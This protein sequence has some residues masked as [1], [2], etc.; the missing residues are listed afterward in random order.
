MRKTILQNKL[1]SSRMPFLWSA[2]WK[3]RATDNDASAQN[4]R[5]CSIKLDEHLLQL[6]GPAW[7]RIPLEIYEVAYLLG[8]KDLILSEIGGVTFTSLDISLFMVIVE[9][10]ALT[11]TKCPYLELILLNSNGGEVVNEIEMLNFSN[12]R[13]LMK[14]PLAE[15]EKKTSIKKLLCTD[16]PNLWSPPH[17]VASQGEAATMDFV[18]EVF[19]D[20]GLNI[21]M[22]LF[23]LGD[24]EAGKTSVL[25]SLK[26][27][28]NAAECIREDLRTVGIDLQ[29]WHV[30]PT[31][32]GPPVHFRVC[33]LAGQEVYEATHQFLL[34]LRAVYILVWRAVPHTDCRHNVLLD[35]VRHWLDLLQMR[36]P[37][38]RLLLVVTHIDT[39]DAK[40]LSTLCSGVKDTV[41]QRLAQ[42][43]EIA[44]Q[45]RLLTVLND[46]ESLRVNCL[47]GEGVAALRE[48]L[49][50]FTQSMPW[51]QE[52]LPKSFIS[53][54]DSVYNMVNQKEGTRFISAHEWVDLAR[55]HGMDGSMLQ[56]EQSSC[57]IL[58]CCAFSVTLQLLASSHH[59]AQ[60]GRLAI[61]F[62][63]LLTI[64]CQL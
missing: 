52:Q 53:V 29:S 26:S 14:L 8:I 31:N 58:V 54:R 6:E 15:I 55:S 4:E 36:V 5:Q 1:T 20:G 19:R 47:L 11:V 61:Q 23:L 17:E 3:N 43:K 32:G 60:N 12:N 57:T 21:E 40:M 59:Q 10:K 64:W 46:G 62:T 13:S 2:L 35:R 49:I 33:D 30:Q 51:F 16:C 18:R 37:G 24:G 45:G 63:S 42:L 50:S 38:A 25:K 28:N 9:L 48:Q 22:T 27:H 7:T 41:T 56:L 34:Q 44:N 39:V